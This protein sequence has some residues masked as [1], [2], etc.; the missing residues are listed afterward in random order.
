VADLLGCAAAAAQGALAAADA[1][2]GEGGGEAADAAGL[3]GLAEQWWALSKTGER[4]IVNPERV[5][6]TSQTGEKAHT[7]GGRWGRRA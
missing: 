5:N 4:T 2:G 3:S 1:G 7:T 6:R